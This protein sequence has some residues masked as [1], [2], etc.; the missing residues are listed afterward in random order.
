MP[1]YPAHLISN[2]VAVTNA[3]AVRGILSQHHLGVDWM[4]DDLGELLFSSR[5]AKLF[6][7]P[8]AKIPPK[9]DNDD[10]AR[11]LWP[12]PQLLY[13]RGEDDFCDM[14][15]TLNPYLT[16]PLSVVFALRLAGKCISGNSFWAEPGKAEVKKITYRDSRS[17]E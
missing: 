13:E 16:E 8:L 1:T 14:L 11:K 5:D 9:P 4:I 15:S 6:A 2:A 10:P 3:G 12:P 7:V 17:V